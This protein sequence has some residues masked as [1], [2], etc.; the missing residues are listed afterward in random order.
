MLMLDVRNAISNI[1]DRF[2][3]AD[4]VEI[5]MRKLRKDKVATPFFIDPLLTRPV[6]SPPKSRKAS[7][8]VN[9]QTVA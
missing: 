6:V 5:T 2:T 8:K 1:L 7:K 9:G 4:V 3:L